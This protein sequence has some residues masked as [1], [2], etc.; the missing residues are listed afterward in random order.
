MNTAFAHPRPPT[1]A[2]RLLEG[3]RDLADRE[4]RMP[5]DHWLP[6]GIP[7]LLQ[8]ERYARAVLTQGTGAVFTPDQVEEAVRLRMHRALLVRGGDV[9]QRFLL[10]RAGLHRPVLDTDGMAAQHRHLEPL[11]DLEHIKIRIVPDTCPELWVGPFTLRGGLV[12]IEGPSGS[13][14]PPGSPKP[15]A[16]V[17]ERLWESGTPYIAE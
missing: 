10:T 7:G 13:H 17:F 15:Y 16:D 11:T 6:L 3:Q 14:T 1:L 9:R 8:T 5:G 2:E 4:Y 12:S